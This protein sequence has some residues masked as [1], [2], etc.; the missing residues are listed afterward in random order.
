MAWQKPNKAEL[1]PNITSL[2]NRCHLQLLK[3]KCQTLTELALCY[4]LFRFNTVSL[5]LAEL[6][7]D[8]YGRGLH[9]GVVE[10]AI[11]VLKVI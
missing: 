8:S 1:S 6:M 5:W 10:K 4:F 9:T 2:I 11:E 3:K 7:V